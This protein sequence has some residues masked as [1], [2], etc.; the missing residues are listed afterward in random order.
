MHFQNDGAT[1]IS[2]YPASNAML[3]KLKRGG[4]KVVGKGQR[5]MFI[6]TNNGPIVY[7]GGS[8]RLTPAMQSHTPQHQSN[9]Y[10]FSSTDA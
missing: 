2:A 8:F 4:V 5:R 10:A 6:I 1:S 7:L 3:L 9:K